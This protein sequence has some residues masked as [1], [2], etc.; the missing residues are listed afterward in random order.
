M[1]II[2]SCLA[3]ILVALSFPAQAAEPPS[4]TAMICRTIE[5]NQCQGSA[6]KF[7]ADV[8][9][10]YGFSVATSVPDKVTHVWFHNDKEKGRWTVGAPANAPRWKSFSNITV[11]RD[12]IGPWRLEIRDSSNAVLATANFTV[13]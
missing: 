13:Q 1:R 10:L 11:T 4:A 5:K 8:G 7:P 6:T 12:M 2:V 3:L 9:K